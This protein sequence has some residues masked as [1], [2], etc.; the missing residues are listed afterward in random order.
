MA[1]ATK[2]PLPQKQRLQRVW[3]TPTARTVWLWLVPTL[4]ICAIISG[5]YYYTLKM[6]QTLDPSV[7][8]LRLFGIV[9]FALVLTVSSYTLRRRFIRQLPGS[10]QGWLWVH[11]W[12]GIAA[13][14]IALLHSNFA[15]LYPTFYFAPSILTDSAGGMSA[16]YGLLLL[17]VT[18][19]IG[20][21]LD[22]WQARAIAHEANRN[23]VGIMQSVQDRLHEIDLAVG[24]LSAGKSAEFQHYCAQVLRSPM[25]LREMPP[26]LPAQEQADFKQAWDAL[27]MYTQLARSL[28]RQKQA[29]A[30]IRGWRYVHIT[31]ACAAFAAITF[32]SGSELIKLAL[33]LLGKPA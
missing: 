1:L 26:A 6:Q 27:A 29:H 12:F 33:Q 16:L 10:V 9:A 15:N 24:R 13:I 5:I 14:I 32:H 18:G 22:M 11:T 23:G 17:V 31:I 25:P 21:V 7:D 19:V 3:K 20:R 30:L 2:Q 8:P 28:R 4:L